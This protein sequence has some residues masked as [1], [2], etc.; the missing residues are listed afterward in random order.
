MNNK[1]PAIIE[2]AN[3]DELMIFEGLFEPPNLE[4][5]EME[6]PYVSHN[7][8]VATKTRWS[9]PKIELF[10]YFSK[11]FEWVQDWIRSYADIITGRFQNPSDYKKTIIIKTIGNDNNLES[12]RWTLTGVHISNCNINLIYDFENQK[13]ISFPEILL[14]KLTRKVLIEKNHNLTIQFFVELELSIDSAFF[15]G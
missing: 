9:N 1:K 3:G 2:I 11:N 13:N 12:E 14:T 15:N 4:I 6:I 8:W 10:D 5:D 7:T